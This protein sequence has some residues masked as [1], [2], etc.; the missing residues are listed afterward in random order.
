MTK[1]TMKSGRDPFDVIGA[2]K[3]AADTLRKSAK[4]DAFVDVPALVGKSWKGIKVGDKLIGRVTGTR[5]SESRKFHNS[6]GSP[7]IQT[8]FDVVDDKGATHSI[9]A[10]GRLEQQLNVALLAFGVGCVVEVTFTGLRKVEGF[11]NKARDFTVRA[12]PGKA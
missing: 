12:K 4:G 2:T 10:S 5:R 9:Y 3:V 6:D 7:K 1:G 11:K 8:V